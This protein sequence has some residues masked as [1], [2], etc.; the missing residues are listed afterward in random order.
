MGGLCSRSELDAAEKDASS[1]APMSRS[2]QKQQLNRQHNSKRA[3]LD[4]MAMARKLINTHDANAATL[5]PAQQSAT[6]LN[7]SAI[8][9]FDSVDD[10]YN[11]RANLLQHEKTLDFDY[12]CR[13]NSTAKERLA[14]VIIQRLRHDDQANVYDTAPPRRG[15]G[16]Q[17]HPRFAGD[18][19]LSN[20]D[21]IN[22]TALFRV[23]RHMPKGAHLHIHFNACLM[24][25]VLLNIAK[26]MDRMF[27]TSD[28]PLLPDGSHESFD[29]CEIQ[30]SI[31]SPEKESP[32]DL[33]SPTYEARQTMKFQDFL[34]SFPQN[35]TKTT[36]DEW[37]LEKLMFHEEEAHN[38]LQTAAGYAASPCFANALTIVGPGRSSMVERR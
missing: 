10:Y 6:S 38:H 12:R 8:S 34:R 1:A 22:Q 31:M 35:Y 11:I 25:H 28:V 37:L 24:P 29:R 4:D 21:L 5:N 30:F 20:L 23:A 27:I 32:G 14:D 18:H 16:G 17:Q 33:F 9:R 13:A 2:F 7:L 3:H 15:F 19:F 36:P 26:G